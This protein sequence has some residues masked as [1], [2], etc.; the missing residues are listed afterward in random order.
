MGSSEL[1]AA[2]AAQRLDS[3][4]DATGTLAGSAEID[5]VAPDRYEI[6]RCLGRGG[7][8]VVYEA[9][10]R[11]R[12]RWVALKTMLLADPSALARFKQEF[13]TLAEVF[14]PNLV[15]LYDFVADADRAFFTM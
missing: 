4:A 9:F 14:H 1:I 10:D 12:E 11:E 5:W 3:G 7:M 13:R 6:R 15:Q 8:G 2:A